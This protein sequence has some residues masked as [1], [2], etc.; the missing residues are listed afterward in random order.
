MRKSNFEILRILA[1]LLIILG[2]TMSHGVLESTYSMNQISFIFFRWIAYSGKIG[3]Y[4]YILISGYFLSSSK[5]SWK[6]VTKLWKNVFFW[7]VILTVVGGYFLKL[8]TLKKIIMS[9]F[10]IIFSQYWF[11]TAYFFLYLLSP[12]INMVIKD[13]N[14]NQEISLLAFTIIIILPGKFLYGYFTYSWLMIFILVYMIGGILRKEKA[15]FNTFL[16][17]KMAYFLLVGGILGNFILSILISD[18]RSFQKL[19]VL[20]GEETIF[21]FFIAVGMFIIFE[22]A[23]DFYS[24]CINL[25]SSTTFSI[26]LIH[27]NKIMEI[28]LWKKLWKMDAISSINIWNIIYIFMATIIT[29]IV[30]SILELIRNKCIEILKSKFQIRSKN[31]E[32]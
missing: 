19:N 17:K 21:C 6:K 18:N 23:S 7:S 5:F 28:F 31:S 11:V 22:S 10:P 12:F 24:K 32:I 20:L 27:D 30:C 1:M 14:H 13:L 3:V 26:Y 2:H 4:L 9:I 25:V 8:L 29:F 16:N 15:F